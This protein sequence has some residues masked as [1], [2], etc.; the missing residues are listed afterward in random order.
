MLWDNKKE[1]IK[2]EKESESADIK[3]LKTFKKRIRNI[4]VKKKDYLY[5]VKKMI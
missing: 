4:Y 3:K 1:E 5:K 2:E